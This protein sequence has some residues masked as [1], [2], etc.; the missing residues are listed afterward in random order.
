M[1]YL[2]KVNTAHG[3]V[4][5]IAKGDEALA[6]LFDRLYAAGPVNT[7]LTVQP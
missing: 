3:P 6:S 4:V 2:V 7:F 5:H 1:T